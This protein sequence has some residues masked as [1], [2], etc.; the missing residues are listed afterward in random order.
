MKNITKVFIV[1]G[2]LVLAF[3][4]WALVFNDGGVLQSGYNGIAGAVN[5]TWA[6]V[7]GSNNAEIMPS[8]NDANVKTEGNLNN[9]GGQGF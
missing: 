8:W 7:T 4:I 6:T 5:N 3:L 2:L 9:A 1:I